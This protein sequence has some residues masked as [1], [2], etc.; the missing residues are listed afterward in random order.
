[1]ATSGNIGKL[2]DCQCVDLA[3]VISAQDM[4]SIALKYFKFSMEKVKSLKFAHRENT[5]AFKRD[6]ID[7][8]VKRNSGP[9]QVKVSYAGIKIVSCRSTKQLTIG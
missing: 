7:A 9:N 3:E 5:D 4:E 2:T 6:V 1:M 8:W